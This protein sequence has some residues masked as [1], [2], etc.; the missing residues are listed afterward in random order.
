MPERTLLESAAAGDW[1]AVLADL[2]SLPGKASR[3]AVRQR[4]ADGDTTLHYVCRGA[5]ESEAE[6]ARLARALI[7][8]GADVD[9]W[10]DEIVPPIAA[11]TYAGALPTV[12][13]LV[14][15]GARLD[16]ERR[17]G[18]PLLYV[19]ADSWVRVGQAAQ[20]G[21]QHCGP[22]QVCGPDEADPRALLIARA[23]QAD[24]LKLARYLIGAGIDVNARTERYRQTAL[25][26][27]VDHGIQPL[28]T[29]LL[30]TPGIDLDA[31]DHLGLTVLHFAAHTGD[32]PLTRR[33]LRAGARPDPVDRYGFT[34]LHEA[35]ANGHAAVAR[36]LLRAGA[37]PRRKLKT[38]FGAFTRGMTPADVARASGH[39][40]VERGA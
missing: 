15:A 13:A 24:L 3:R 37:N 21:S 19:I 12:R 25:F 30:R 17:A 39:E 1:E 29:L 18:V 20:P 8:A 34:P 38:D 7:A 9:A 35:A 14:S 6:R 31:R 2:R 23:F 40:F 32:V 5:F 22:G 26:N 33:L 16:V 4:E 28:I 11:A 10:S 27:A 36:A